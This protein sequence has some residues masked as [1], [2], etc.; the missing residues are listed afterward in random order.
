MAASLHLIRYMTLITDFSCLQRGH[1]LVGDPTVCVLVAA[2]TL[3][4]ADLT[5]MEEGT[6]LLHR[7]QDHLEQHPNKE[8]RQLA[9]T[10]SSTGCC[11]SHV[12]RSRQGEMVQPAHC[13]F[14]GSCTTLLRV[15]WPVTG[16]FSARATALAI[17]CKF[18]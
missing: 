1:V 2:D 5:I 17:C 6:E 12:I 7:L 10:Q 11:Y 18:P 4:G 9:Q 3:F 15:D 16:R 14:G 8:V 13:N